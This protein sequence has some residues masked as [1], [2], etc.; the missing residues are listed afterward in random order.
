MTLALDDTDEYESLPS[1]SV[2]THM[3]AGA[4]AGTAEHCVMYPLDSVKTRMQSLVPTPG[5]EYRGVMNTL[6]QMVRTE[7]VF[8]PVRGMSAVMIGAG[9]AHAL[10]FSCYERIKEILAT[11][12]A[13]AGFNNLIYGAAGC[14]ATLFHDGIM[15]PADVVKQRMQMYN[16]PYKSCWDCVKKTYHT[17]GAHAFYR[18]YTTQLGMNI[19]F[20]SIHFMVYEFM[21]RITNK[22]RRYNPKA[23]MVSG[24]MAGAIASAI[25]TPLDVCKTLLNTQERSAL[26]TLGRSQIS[27][28]AV[29]FKTVYRLGGPKGYFQGLSARVL[30]QMPSTAICWS[31][32]EF[33]KFAMG[34]H[35]VETPPAAPSSSGHV[36]D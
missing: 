4:I 2:I 14:L 13:A 6:T 25:T 26:N 33:F 20:Q 21:Q 34:A 8:R 1:G 35:E 29:A 7:G 10:Y 22:E 19:P 11:H 31:V 16:S 23:H 24:A 32:Y 5:G 17:E 9:P 36:I 18:S 28:L 27:G 15:T 12:T 3:I 30:Y